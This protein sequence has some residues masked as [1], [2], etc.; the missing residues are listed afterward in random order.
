M[1]EKKKD[2]VAPK[3]GLVLTGG[4][5]RAAYQ[6]G[7]LRAIAE[8]LP[9]KSRNPFPVIC[10]TSAGAINAAS[11]AVAANNFAEGVAQL[12]DV[13]SNFHVNQI[14]RSDLVGVMHNTLRCMLSLVSSEYGQHNPISLLDNAPLETL[15]SSRFSF[16]AIQHCIRSG[17][18]HALGLTAWGYTSG[19][20][21]TFYQAARE[22]RPWK[23]A[24]R[25]GV[26]VEIGV[27]HLMASS[28]I[29][30]IFPA[31]K[32]N[33]E[34]FG[35]GSM[36]QMAPISPALH[37][38]ADK[39]LIIGVRKPV[40]NEPK[41]TSTTSYPPF[42]QIAGH[43]LNSIFV[44]SLDVDLERLLRINETLKLIPHE[45][46]KEKNISLR[47]VEAMM[48]APSEGINVIA[49]KYAFTLPWI[50][51]SLYRAIGAMGPN[52]STLLSYV[53]FEV[54]FCRH[55][56]ELGYN[57]T[58][59]QKDELLKFIGVQDKVEKNSN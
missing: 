54:P 13:W 45:V 47:P 9:D 22:V 7:V 6:V 50:M 49:Q 3:V 24:Q 37:L 29:P 20:S 23:R 15:L 53:L 33:R 17:S 57:D 42:A 31:V 55:L 36:R 48:I 2:L 14:Y 41:R 12:E 35:D 1:H 4:G 8:M 59:Q 21:V 40:T 39:V 51:R 34:F 26:P 56:I 19:Q 5:A 27:E 43:A 28:S 18:L 25:L 52:G 58:L 38:G 10:G 44:D 16:R 11:I 30:F 32:L 46:F